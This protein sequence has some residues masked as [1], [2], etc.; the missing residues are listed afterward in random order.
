[1]KKYSDARI[2]ISSLIVVL[3]LFVAGYHAGK[4]L[5]EQGNVEKRST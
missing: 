1:M 5:A 3:G 2:L 4:Y